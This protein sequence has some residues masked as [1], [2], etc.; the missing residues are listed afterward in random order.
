MKWKPMRDCWRVPKADYL[1]SIG[2]EEFDGQKW[3]EVGR[4]FL[5]WARRLVA[6]HNRGA[7]RDAH[8]AALRGDGEQCEKR[9][10]E[11]T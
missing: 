7:L 6:A 10:K 1:G 9:G 11:K 3:N 8:N 5:D 2:I 4:A